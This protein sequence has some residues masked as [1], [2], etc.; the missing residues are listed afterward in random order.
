MQ[1]MLPSSTRNLGRPKPSTRPKSQKFFAQLNKELG[2]AKAEH[3][4]QVA[5]IS[6]K[7]EAEKAKSEATVRRLMEE[8][9]TEKT[10]PASRRRIFAWPKPSTRQR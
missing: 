2:A 1:Q 10:S 8:L 5:K 7:V 9:E 6:E 4:A 3:M